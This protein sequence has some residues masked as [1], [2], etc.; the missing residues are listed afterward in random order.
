MQIRI[1]ILVP[2]SDMFPTLGKDLLTGFKE[3]VNNSDNA[4]T[5]QY[6]VEGIG[7][8]ATDSL[9]RAAEKMILQEDVDLTISFC[10]NHI[11]ERLVKVFDAYKKPLIHV[12]LGSNV[13]KE[14]HHSPYVA[15]HSLNIWQ[16]AYA[17]GKYAAEKYGKKG[18]IS[19]SYYDGGYQHSQAF[20]AGYTDH[21]GEIAHFY[22]APMEYQ[23]ESYDAMIDGMTEANPDVAFLLFSYKEGDKVLNV[24]S[25]SELNGKIP[26]VAIPTLTDE[27]VYE[28]N[29]KLDG[30]VSVASW[31]FDDPNPVMKGFV[32]LMDEKHQ[33]APNIMHLLGYEMGQLMAS[34]YTEYECI[35]NDISEKLRNLTTD[36]PRGVL[37]YNSYGESQVDSFKIRKFNFNEVRY[38]NTVVDTMDTSITA[39]LYSRFEALEYGGWQNPYIC[40]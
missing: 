13:I 7:A 22:V 33:T 12:G 16:A 2:R 28:S 32:D 30:V 24:L 38:H 26:F 40:T 9:V 39:N 31:A 36:S 11:L 3:G 21:G 23:K 8:A 1:G 4:P 34:L 20:V 18:S 25:E 10:S 29:H 6:L 35:P 27:S 19:T 17:A 14:M 5:I 37:T 15:Y